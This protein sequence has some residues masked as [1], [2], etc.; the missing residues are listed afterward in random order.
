MTV[1]RRHKLWAWGTQWRSWLRHWATSREVAGSIPDGV[2]GIF[3]W[4]HPSGRT[5][6]RRLTQPLTETSTRNNSWWVKAVR[7]YGWQRC[8]RHMPTVLISGSLTLLET[9]GSVQ[10]CNGIALPLPLQALGVYAT[11]DE[12]NIFREVTETDFWNIIMFIKRIITIYVN[13]PM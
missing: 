12:V 8:H 11:R 13:H 4:H 2:T 5:M 1:W 10:A 6:A 7:A 9:Y 3:H